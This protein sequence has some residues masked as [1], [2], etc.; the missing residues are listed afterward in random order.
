MD[1]LV[2]QIYE[3][4]NKI[5]IFEKSSK[6]YKQKINELHDELNF[7]KNKLEEKMNTKLIIA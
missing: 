2:Y 7:L 1:E 5:I 6:L 4:M 3:L